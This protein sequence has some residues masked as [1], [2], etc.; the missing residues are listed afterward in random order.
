MLGIEKM[1]RKNLFRNYSS[2][3]ARVQSLV[4]SEQAEPKQERK[5]LCAH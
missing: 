5:Y 3:L 4:Q 2:G 1:E